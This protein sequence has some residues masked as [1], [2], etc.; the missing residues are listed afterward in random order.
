[1]STISDILNQWKGLTG[2][3]LKIVL[4]DYKWVTSGIMCYVLHKIDY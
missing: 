2:E 4:R 3:I 1:M